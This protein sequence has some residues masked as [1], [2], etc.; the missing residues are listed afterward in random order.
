MARQVILV[1]TEQSISEINTLLEEHFAQDGFACRNYRGELTLSREDKFG[2]RFFKV[3]HKPGTL[4]IEAWIKNGNGELALDNKLYGTRPKKG[5]QRDVNNLMQ[6]FSDRQC[7]TFHSDTVEGSLMNDEYQVQSYVLNS[8]FKQY[9]ILSLGMGIVSL[10]API[11]YILVWAVA[12]GAFCYGIRG[13][14]SSM[15]WASFLG[16]PLSIVSLVLSITEYIKATF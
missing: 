3:Y 16:I 5:L 2:R 15:K 11:P 7:S 10:V 9:S 12:V 1:P 14:R 6:L 13:I 4:K 8:D